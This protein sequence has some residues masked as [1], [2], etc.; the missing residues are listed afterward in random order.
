MR[1]GINLLL[2]LRLDRPLVKVGIFVGSCQDAF[3]EFCSSGEIDSFMYQTVGQDAIELVAGA[4]GV[5][6]FRRTIHGAAVEQGG[7]YGDREGK[8]DRSTEGVIGD[9]TEDMF[10]LL[11]EVKVRWAQ[12]INQ[13]FLI[14]YRLLTQIYKASLLA[15]SSLTINE[16]GLTMCESAASIFDQAHY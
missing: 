2:L 1:M 5:P 8:V 11:S 15:R 12:C 16:S 14:L 6:L 7:E 13:I 9:E 10:D 4:L 3:L